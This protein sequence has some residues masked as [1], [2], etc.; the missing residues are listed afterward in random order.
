MLDRGHLE[1]IDAVADH[2]Y[3]MTATLRSEDPLERSH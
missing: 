1:A 3:D 2:R